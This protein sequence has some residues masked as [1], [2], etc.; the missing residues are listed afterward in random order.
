M[1][2]RALKQ[3]ID[4]TSDHFAAPLRAV[5]IYEDAR[6]LAR[7]NDVYARLARDLGFNCW[8]KFG[9]Q[10]SSR[11]AAADAGLISFP[12]NA[13]AK[14]PQPKRAFRQTRDADLEL[15]PWGWVAW[16]AGAFFCPNSLR[17]PARRGATRE[18]H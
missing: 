17:H 16:R 13:E 15:R 18:L 9:E 12:A 10:R 4:E 5:G 14:P 8:I 1:S 2:A 6:G 3:Q 11:L 7:R